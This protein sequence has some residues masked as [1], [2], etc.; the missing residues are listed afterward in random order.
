MHDSEEA[1]EWCGILTS[2][3]AIVIALLDTHHCAYLQKIYKRLGPSTFCLKSLGG[4]VM[5]SGG[6][7]D[8]S[9]H[10]VAIGKVLCYSRE[11]FT[12]PTV[13]LVESISP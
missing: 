7:I 4:W 5:V 13:T 6:E 11:P 10:A 12:L 3:Y 1:G 2:G 9:F 8:V